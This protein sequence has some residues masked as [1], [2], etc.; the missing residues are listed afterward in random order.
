MVLLLA[1][2]ADASIPR[3]VLELYE[4]G[5]KV[6]V[7]M[8]PNVKTDFNDL[9]RA[10]NDKGGGMASPSSY[11]KENVMRCLSQRVPWNEIPELSDAVR[12]LQLQKI[13]QQRRRQMRENFYH[14]H[15]HHHHPHPH[16]HDGN[17][18]SNEAA[19]GNNNDGYSSTD[20][21]DFDPISPA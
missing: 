7:S 4:G 1:T 5:K 18:P 9:L 8:P 3:A 11:G 13:E 16:H 20:E 12:A 17:N 15:H 21:D 14:R 2:F 6:L 19:A 10:V